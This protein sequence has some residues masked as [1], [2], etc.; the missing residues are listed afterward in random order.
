MAQKAVRKLSFIGGSLRP[1]G[2]IVDVPDEILKPRSDR[3]KPSSDGASQTVRESNLV[4]VGDAK[5]IAI[6]PVA[7]IGPTGPNPVAPQ[8]VPAGT[9]TAGGRYTSPS[10]EMLVGEGSELAR[11]A[12]G[13]NGSTTADVI[14]EEGVQRAFD[15]DGDGKDGGSKPKDPPSLSGMN[16]AELLDQAK[17]EGVTVKDGATN[18]EIA[19]AIEAKRAA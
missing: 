2:A 13:Q 10:G 5:R 3:E 17:A 14:E 1:P 12:E 8:Q 15:H 4:D 11:S 7:A 19:E 16:K 6:A 18:A 9:S